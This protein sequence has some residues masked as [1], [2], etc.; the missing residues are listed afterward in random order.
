MLTYHLFYLE[1]YSDDLK[2]NLQL[3]VFDG[4][5]KPRGFIWVKM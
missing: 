1:N 4:E 2:N 3:E 5:S